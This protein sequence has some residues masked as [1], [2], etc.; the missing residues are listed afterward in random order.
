MND[1][2]VPAVMRFRGGVITVLSHLQLFGLGFQHFNYLPPLFM[3]LLLGSEPIAWFQL[4]SGMWAF[5]ANA[6]RASVEAEGTLKQI[7]NL[8]TFLWTPNE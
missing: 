1:P 5:L 3:L 2:I 8:A 6:S 4:V 7:Q